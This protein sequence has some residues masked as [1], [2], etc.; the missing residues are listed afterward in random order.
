[1]DFLI[2]VV[3][4]QVTAHRRPAPITE[5]G[6]T[7]A[8][9]TNREY[10]LFPPKVQVFVRAKRTDRKGFSIFLKTPITE[11]EKLLARI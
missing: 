9:K 6:V 10:Q 8:T 11:Y 3:P 4:H 7:P 1:V 5:V 2:Q